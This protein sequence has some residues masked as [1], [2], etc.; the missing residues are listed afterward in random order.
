MALITP[1]TALNMT[2][3]FGLRPSNLKYRATLPASADRSM[4]VPGDAPRYMA[5]IK[6]EGAAQV[7]VAVNQPAETPIGSTFAAT[8]SEMV[9]YGGVLCREVEADDVLHF[10]TAG[11]DIDVN[12]VL[13]S[14]KSTNGI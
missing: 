8:G 9:P 11:T 12:V 2:D 13:Y 4:T 6:A 7:Y 5:I 1:W 10:I 14:L 3:D